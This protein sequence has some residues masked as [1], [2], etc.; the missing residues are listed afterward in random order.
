MRKR[1][2]GPFAF[3][4]FAA[5][6]VDGTT[7]PAP[8]VTADAA[9]VEGSCR[10]TDNVATK[11]RTMSGNCSNSTVKLPAG[12]TVE[13]DR[14]ALTS[15]TITGEGIQA[16]Q[17]IPR[18]V[19][20]YTSQTSKIDI[21]GIPE[22]TV[23]SSISDGTRT[24]NF[25]SPMEKRTVGFSWGTW[26][27]PPLAEDAFPPILFSALS[28]SVT[29]ILSG[30]VQAF[31]FELEPNLFDI[32]SATVQFYSAQR[33]LL[34][35]VTRDVDGSSGARLFAAHVTS[36]T[37][38]IRGAIAVVAPNATSGSPLGFAIAQV[39]YAP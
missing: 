39:R 10:V 30:G 3:A 31:G 17:R 38:K 24:V 12:W 28:D 37:A 7:S 11:V 23:V 9:I 18:P 15:E 33:Q 6:C 34:G 32:F 14:P 25:S 19:A 8:R 13:F 36:P 4:I 29:M 2:A 22:F 26:A 5:A 1:L 35:S 21:S 16:F 27:S 20:Q